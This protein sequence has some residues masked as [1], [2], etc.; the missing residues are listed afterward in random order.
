MKKLALGCLLVSMSG[1]SNMAGNK[2]FV[3][4]CVV[5]LTQMVATTFVDRY[6]Y[7]N[8]DQLG[9]VAG[10]AIP[11]CVADFVGSGALMMMGKV[12][13]PLH[14]FLGSVAGG[15]IFGESIGYFL[16]YAARSGE[17]K[18][19]EWDDTKWAAKLLS[20]VGEFYDNIAKVGSVAGMP[21]LLAIGA[22]YAWAVQG[23]PVAALPYTVQ[24]LVRR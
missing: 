8:T 24:L 6:N 15:L 23:R 7:K 9:C 4:G 16:N 19:R 17:G 12:H 21:G 1:M 11:V 2:L 14:Y 20:N 18:K 5:G 10:N 13:M 3:A 22:L